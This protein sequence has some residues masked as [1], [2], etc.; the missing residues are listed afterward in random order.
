[1]V[2]DKSKQKPWNT[3][4]LEGRDVRIALKFTFS[5]WR[6]KQTTA[7]QA[8]LTFAWESRALF[9]WMI[10][11]VDQ[12]CVITNYEYDFAVTSL[13]SAVIRP[14]RSAW[15]DH[16]AKHC[17]ITVALIPLISAWSDTEIFFKTYQSAYATSLLPTVPLKSGSSFRFL[18]KISHCFQLVA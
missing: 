11:I 18:Q 10:T 12:V 15:K 9:K 13:V 16:A 8:D 17:G 7:R 14:H 4:A 3:F 5:V 6:S 2:L 1:M